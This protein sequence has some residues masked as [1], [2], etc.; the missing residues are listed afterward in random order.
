MIISFCLHTLFSG[1]EFGVA[2]TNVMNPIQIADP[3][4]T[5]NMPT[6]DGLHS[7]YSRRRLSA[8]S[9]NNYWL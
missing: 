7:V 8:F 3:L 1:V 9:Q 5:G 6:E 2:Y 4:A